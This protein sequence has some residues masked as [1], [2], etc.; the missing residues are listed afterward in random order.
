MKRNFY[1]TKTNE[2]AS[3]ET[4]EIEYLVF[5]YLNEPHFQRM[6]AMK[7]P[8]DN[9]YSK[10]FSIYHTIDTPMDEIIFIKD[11][12][13]VYFYTYE[14]NNLGKNGWCQCKIIG[15]GT[16]DRQKKVRIA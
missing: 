2:N 1:G 3:N 8:S 4:I 13:L 16:N 11:E 15:R 5:N 10:D 14:I 7:D 12:K 9:V 6:R